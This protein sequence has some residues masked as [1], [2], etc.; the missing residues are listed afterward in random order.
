MVYSFETY[1]Q[2]FLTMVDGK[3]Y[4][5]AQVSLGDTDLIVN[6]SNKEYLFE[7]K[8]YRYPKQFQDD[9]GQLAFYARSLSLDEA[10]YLVFVPNNIYYPEKIKEADEVINEVRVRTFLVFYDEEKDFGIEG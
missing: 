2:A 4:R 10:V 7:I 3:S 9:K 5:E 6:I 1:L 8:V